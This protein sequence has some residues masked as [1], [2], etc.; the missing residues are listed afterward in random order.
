MYI[1]VQK[2]TNMAMSGLLLMRKM[3]PMSGMISYIQLNNLNKTLMKNY[4]MK[5]RHVN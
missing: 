4:Q 1:L 5:D 3:I 2:G